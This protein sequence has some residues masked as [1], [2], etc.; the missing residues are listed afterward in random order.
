[1]AR[2]SAPKRIK[3]RLD[4][5]K[6]I[7]DAMRQTSIP[8]PKNAMRM[9]SLRGLPSTLASVSG[10]RKSMTVKGASR[11]KATSML[12]S[13][14]NYQ[15]YNHKEEKAYDYD[16]D[17]YSVLDEIRKRVIDPNYGQDQSRKDAD[18]AMELTKH[19]LQGHTNQARRYQRMGE[20]FKGMRAE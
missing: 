6:P 13:Y 1:M 16:K 11:K 19:G 3:N 12:G 4:A 15:K 9:H 17:S 5:K 2:R 14:K 10:K 18:L 7:R 20:I 8:K